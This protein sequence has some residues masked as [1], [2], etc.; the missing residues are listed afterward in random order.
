MDIYISNISNISFYGIEKIISKLKE[1]DIIRGRKNSYSEDKI[2]NGIN[3]LLLKDIIEK[4]YKLNYNDLTLIYND[5]KIEIK[6]LSDIK[7]NIVNT[8]D[9]T[10]GAL[11]NGD[12]GMAMEK[13]QYGQDLEDLIAILFTES[14][15]NY[16]FHGNKYDF[17]NRFYEILTAKE[18]LKRAVVNGYYG[19]IKKISVSD[20]EKILSEII[21]NGK[22]YYIKSLKILTDY[23]F[24]L[25]TLGKVEDIDIIENHWEKML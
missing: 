8:E 19:D 5:G 23:Q 6:E 10:L 3:E 18:S 2:I 11:Y 15:K 1:E 7:F 9:Y 16:V 22:I 24:S 25:C 4:K 17:I 14:E 13:L 21:V 20:G 12:I